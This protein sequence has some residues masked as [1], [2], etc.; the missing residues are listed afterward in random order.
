MKE[1]IEEILRNRKEAEREIESFRQQMINTQ[2]EKIFMKKATTSKIDFISSK[3]EIKEID[4][5]RK[6]CDALKAKLASGIIVLGGISGHKVYF[7][8][9]VTDDLVS[10]GFHAGKIVRQV[11]QIAGGS[12]GGRKDFAQAGGKYPDRID[13]ALKEVQTILNKTE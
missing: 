8:A 5:L 2:V 12:G 3:V 9:A 13:E 7:V 4:D 11:A 1:K 6:L 10:K